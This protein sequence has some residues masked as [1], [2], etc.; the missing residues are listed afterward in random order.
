MSSISESRS[1]MRTAAQT[2]ETLTKSGRNAVSGG[3]RAAHLHT[4]ARAE[5]DPACAQVTHLPRSSRIAAFPPG[6]G[7]TFCEGA[8]YPVIT[9]VPLDKMTIYHLL[10]EF[11]HRASPPYRAAFPD[12]VPSDSTRALTRC[13]RA[14]SLRTR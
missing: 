12:V 5:S 3:M 14:S 9:A 7:A 11:S 1:L 10:C 2:G 6:G 8:V 13:T 4:H